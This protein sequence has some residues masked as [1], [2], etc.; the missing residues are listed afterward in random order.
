MISC[1]E[2]LLVLSN[3]TQYTLTKEDV[4]WCLKFVYIPINL[5]GPFNCPLLV[6]IDIFVILNYISVFPG[7]EGEA[8]F[9]ITE[10][11]RKGSN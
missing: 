9:A 10:A 11:V 4:G 3:S 5:E 8:A 7:Q 2:F 6:C 1:S